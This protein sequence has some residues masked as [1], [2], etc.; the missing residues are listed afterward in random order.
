MKDILN[1]KIY[2]EVSDSP[3]VTNILEL[4]R[5]DGMG[6]SGGGNGIVPRQN[7]AGQ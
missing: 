4:L 1:D 5:M 6:I 3:A 2:N 7:K